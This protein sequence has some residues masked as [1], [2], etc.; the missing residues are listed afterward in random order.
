MPGMTGV[1]FLRRARRVAP[2]TIRIMLTGDVSQQTA[3]QAMNVGDVYRFI[4]KP[5]DIDHMSAALDSNSPGDR[6][7]VLAAMALRMH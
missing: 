4:N 3:V 2:R 5:C 6:Q 7:T 1:E